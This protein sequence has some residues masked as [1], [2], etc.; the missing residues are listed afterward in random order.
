MIDPRQWTF[1]DWCGVMARAVPALLLI[2]GAVA[3]PIAL[4]TLP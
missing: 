2:I 1:G 3:A 4:V